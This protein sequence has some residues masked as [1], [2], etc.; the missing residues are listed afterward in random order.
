M[1]Q[2]KNAPQERIVESAV[3][4]F[5]RQGYSGT[6]TRQIADLAVVNEASIFRYFPKKQDLFWA[7]LYSR[8]QRLHVRKALQDG[9][10]NDGGPEQ[11]VPLI[12]QLMVHIAVCQPELIRLLDVGFVELRPGTER[13]Y[14]EFVGPI[15]QSISTYLKRCID[16][17]T[18]R[19]LDPSITAAV[20][21]T[22]VLAHQGLNALLEGKPAPYANADEAVA[23]YSRFWLNALLPKERGAAENVA[24]VSRPA[25]GA[26]VPSAP[27]VASEGVDA[28]G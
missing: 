21:T 15:L 23:A 14:R 26:N 24:L 19:S 20:F 17:G 25:V 9:L 27:C 5:S 2:P 12:I 11:I 7:A 28:L 10:A 13:A 4:L 3:Q 8:L 1:K 16:S 22:T 6:T 18:L